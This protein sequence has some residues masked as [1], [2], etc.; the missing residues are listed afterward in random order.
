MGHRPDGILPG[1]SRAQD[2]G[3]AAHPAENG[4]AL[5]H[6]RN[7][8]V[9]VTR[10]ERVHRRLLRR[11]HDLAR[12]G[13]PSAGVG[14][15]PEDHGLVH[16]E[17]GVRSLDP[18]HDLAAGE[19]VSLGQG[20]DPD[21]SVPQEVPHLVA[22]GQHT[23][24]AGEDLGDDRSISKAE[25]P[26]DLERADK[27]DVRRRTGDDLFVGSAVQ[28]P[29]GV[30]GVAADVVERQERRRVSRHRAV[31]SVAEL[32]NHEIHGGQAEQDCQ[33]RGHAK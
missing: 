15:H 8:G 6:R 17:S 33:R 31:R 27:V 3:G 14:Q 23:L 7:R 11:G 4:R 1:E 10:A 32:G 19:D 28:P 18:H 29:A 13:R 12:R 20:L 26:Q 21:A 16:P 9:D 30:D 2:A 24:A 5:H 22:A 25:R